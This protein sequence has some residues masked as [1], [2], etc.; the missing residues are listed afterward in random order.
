MSTLINAILTLWFGLGSNS[1]FSAAGAAD[2]LLY[3][4]DGRVSGA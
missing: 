4:T 3:Q 2:V 1:G